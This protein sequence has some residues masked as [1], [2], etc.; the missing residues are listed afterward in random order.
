MSHKNLLASLAIIVVAGIVSACIDD[1]GASSGGV[2]RAEYEDLL[3][4]VEALEAERPGDRVVAG[5]AVGASSLAKAAGDGTVLG[6]AVG[7]LPSNVPAYQSRLFT[8]KSAQG[9]LYSVPNEP[10]ANGVVGIGG[11]GVDGAI[12]PLYYE[13]NDCTGAPYASGADVSEYGA[14]Q[15]VVFRLHAGTFN[16]VIDSPS[17]YFYIVA[18]TDRRDG[19]IYASRR[20]N[21]G[22]CELASGTLPTS[23]LVQPNDS[24]AT[25]VESA[26]IAT[27]VTLA[28]P[29]GP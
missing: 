19:M 15:G 2:T 20:V 14:Q 6:T 1:S 7:F 3:A 5:G 21:V 26:P 11:L 25:G 28:A 24:A 23:F 22:S 17:Q 13:N 9:Y 4:R 18:G 12:A 10:N 16:E 8:L 29:S 27:P